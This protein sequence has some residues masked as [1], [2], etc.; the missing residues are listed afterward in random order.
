MCDHGRSPAFRI[1]FFMK[2]EQSIG[3][4]TILFSMELLQKLYL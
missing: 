2:S 4:G 1:N 3:G